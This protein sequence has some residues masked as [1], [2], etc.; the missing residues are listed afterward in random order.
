MRYH[1]IK[2]IAKKLRNDQTPSERLL[3]TYLKRRK[4]LG[5]KFLRQHPIIFESKNNHHWF[6]VPDFYCWEERIVIELDGPIHDAQQ[7]RDAK[8]DEILKSQ[9][10]KILRIKN[11]EL[12]NIDRVL[13]SISANF[14]PSNNYHSPP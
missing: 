7:E 8:R 2:R 6:Y 11:E 3:W 5:R 10:F 12:T 4:L 1:E 13:K 9:G 14:N